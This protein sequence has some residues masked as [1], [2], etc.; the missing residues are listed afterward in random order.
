[1][2]VTTNKDHSTTIRGWWK[3]LRSKNKTEESSRKYQACKQ[4]LFLLGVGDL[5]S[6]EVSLKVNTKDI[7]PTSR[8]SVAFKEDLFLKDDLVN[9]LLLRTVVPSTCWTARI[10]LITSAKNK[11]RS[12]QREL[13]LSL[14]SLTQNRTGDSFSPWFICHPK[15]FC[16][17]KKKLEVQSPCTY[18]T[19]ETIQ[20]LSR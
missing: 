1:M 4:S 20:S 15:R 10:A 11:L 6:P 8:L 14:R 7:C 17:M 3:R 19:T 5:T 13:G 9:S 12:L 16:L 2:Q 18:L